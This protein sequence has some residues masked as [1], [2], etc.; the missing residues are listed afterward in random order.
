MTRLTASASSNDPERTAA[1]PAW[2]P[3]FAA[4]VFAAGFAAR[5]FMP[6]DLRP[7][8]EAIAVALLA[9]GS[10]LLLVDAGLRGR[11]AASSLALLAPIA[12]IPPAWN[13]DAAGT[14]LAIDLATA[15]V[16]GF[17]VRTF[18]AHGGSVALRRLAA[19]MV[20]VFAAFGLAQWLYLN[21]AVREA[22]EAM[23]HDL[24]STE[25][26]RAFLAS[27]RARATFTSP[28]AFA[29]WLA[30]LGP[31]VVVGA[32]SHSRSLGLVAAVL[33][34]AAFGAAG[35][36][37]AAVAL[38][39][40]GVV[41]ARI[42]TEPG[43]RGRRLANAAAVCT[44]I[45]ALAV[46]V[47]ALTSGPTGGKLATL[48]ER[49]DYARAGLRLLADTA[50]FGGGFG[51]VDLRAATAFRP[52]ESFSRSLHN[53]W[54]EGAVEMGVWFLPF[55]AM[56]LILAR[57]VVLNLL[58]ATNA[59]RVPQSDGAGAGASAGGPGAGNA[60]A[61][62]RACDGD[63]GGLRDTKTSST[64]AKGV[65]VGVFLAGVLHPFVGFLPPVWN[66]D[67][68][69]E[70]VLVA[71][72]TAGAWRIA[73]AFRFSGPAGSV[74]LLCGYLA[75]LIHGLVDFDLAIA[76]VA[77]GFG[78]TSGLISGP[79]PAATVASRMLTLAL[80]LTTAFALPYFALRSAGAI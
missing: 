29:G 43:G 36:A 21:E 78:L 74:A 48:G 3:S 15:V 73:G 80:G 35:S 59:P 8:A 79:P 39:I 64:T 13:S 41:V 54:L 34:G 2:L 18:A 65:L 56:M 25:R 32:W 37:G 30:M 31:L 10:G 14:K 53:W 16:A 57:R 11:A 58:S 9:F 22:A 47:M 33:V 28:N 19:T 5:T 38:L 75:F 7:A 68:W 44:A 51:A 1:S 40:A 61:N 66:V 76:G 69:L 4:G 52:G 50:P 46:I 20:L 71:A 17:A 67:P 42:R 63:D 12:L 77:A 70:A 49:F 27:W 23:A 62:E 26:G 45:G 60:S 6:E 24:A 72:A 55:V